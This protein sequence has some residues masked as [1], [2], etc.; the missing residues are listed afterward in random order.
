MENKGTIISIKNQIIEVEFQSHQPAI[1]DVLIAEGDESVKMEVFTSAPS[2]NGNPKFYCLA[3]S[4]VSGLYRGKTVINTKESIT[5]PVGQEVLGRI[6]DI[7]GNPIDGKG[8]IKTSQQKPIY[9]Q[10][11][12]FKE[13]TPPKNV[14]ETGIKI[15]DFFSPI[16]QGGKVGLFGG[17]GVGKTIL[18]T[19]IIHNIV[20][21]NKNK[22]VSVFAGVGERV[23]EGQELS[24]S[25]E[26]SNVLSGVSLIYGHM[27][28]N[29]AVRFRTAIAG[30]ALAEYFRDQLQKNV[31]FFID[32]IFRFAQAGYE[33]A[34]LMNTIPS[35]GGYQATLSSEMA[36][37]QERLVSTKGSTITSFE[38]IYVPSDDLTDYGVQSVFPYLDSSVVLS[39]A[40]YQEGRFPSVDMLA[41]TS[42]GLNI[43]MVGENHYQTLLDAQALL[44][45]A[46]TLERIASL[47][48][49]GE[50]STNDQVIYTRSKILK[51]YMTQG[52]FV[53]TNQTGREGKYVPLAETVKDVRRV[54]DGQYDEWNPE[55]FL[56]V[57]SLKELK[58]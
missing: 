56:F 18:L 54:L 12:N 19:E 14:L 39:R 40:I 37:L 22:N 31:L 17:A 50:L 23:R 9:A 32:N 21:L 38:A 43:E 27:G 16:L 10:N 2:E 48:G 53:V 8:E 5:L 3:L 24:E 11:V 26:Q 36:T 25:L 44:K 6:I 33:L 28:D 42:S 47:I 13:L 57:G 7:F 46:L 55:K 4:P 41:S 15:I 34:T 58:K 52:F 45:K 29:P 20:I 30:V 35:E 1:H 49:E 51:N